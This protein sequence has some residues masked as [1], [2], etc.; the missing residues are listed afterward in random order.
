MRRAV[1]ATPAVERAGADE[2]SRLQEAGAQNHLRLQHPAQAQAAV[3]FGREK[4]RVHRAQKGQ[5]GRIR[6]AV[7]PF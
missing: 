2:M 6:A 4:G 3:Y 1:H 7:N 5:Q